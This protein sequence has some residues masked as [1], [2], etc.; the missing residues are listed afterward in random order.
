MTM[1]LILVGGYV[2]AWPLALLV[3]PWLRSKV[4]PR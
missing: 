1:L 2:L 3:A 4:K